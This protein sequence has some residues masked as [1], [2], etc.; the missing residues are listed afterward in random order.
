MK[1]LADEHIELSV[2][3]GLRNLGI[4]IVSIDELDKKGYMDIDILDFAKENNKTVITRDSDFLKFLAH[5][6]K[7]KGIIFISTQLSIGEVIN[8]VEKISLLFDSADLENV[9]IF[10]PFR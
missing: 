4:D 3:N 8:E 1:F 9:V 7:H 5:R 2:V 6:V 10:I